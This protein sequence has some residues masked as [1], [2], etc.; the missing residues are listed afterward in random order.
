MRPGAFPAV[1]ALTCAVAATAAA[2][3]ELLPA[4]TGLGWEN[5]WVREWRRDIPGLE[6]RDRVA[7]TPGFVKVVRRWTWNGGKPLRDVVLSL[8]Y[9]MNGDPAA[10]KPFIPGTL[11]FGNPSNKGR[12]DGRVPVYSGEE[13][14]FAIFEEHRLP[15]PFAMLENAKTGDFAALHPVPSPIPVSMGA[16]CEDQWWSIGVAARKD[17]ADIVVLSGPIGYNRR[18][19][20]V[21]S[22][23]YDWGDPWEDVCITLAPGQSVEKTVLVQTGKASP[24]AAGFERCVDASLSLYRPEQFLERH[25]KVDEIL[26]VKRDYIMSRWIDE[27]GMRGFNEWDP[28]FGGTK[29]LKTIHLGWTGCTAAPAYA[30]AVLNLGEGDRDKAQKTLD[31]IADRFGPTIAPG[32]GTFKTMLDVRTG[33]LSGGDPV[34]CGQALYSVLKAV[35]FAERNPSSG[36]DPAKWKEFSRKASREIAVGLLA[37]NWHAPKS[38]GAAFLIAPLV[39]A[40][41][42][43]SMPECFAAA[44][45]LADF[46]A[47]NYS[48][49]DKTYWGGSLDATC[50]DKEGAMAAF[51][52][53]VA[54]LRHAIA[55]GDAAEEKRFA[56]L[57]RHAMHMALSWTVVWNITMPRGRTL[58]KARFR[59]AGWTVV[60]VQ[61]QCLDVFAL[62]TVPELVWM[63][64]Y[65]GDRRLEDLAMLMF[66]SCFQLTA[67]DG[68]TGEQILHTN[69]RHMWDDFRLIGK[70][71]DPRTF[72]GGFDPWNP[73]WL[74]GH[75]LC[76]AA[77]LESLPPLPGGRA[78]LAEP[79]AHRA[80]QP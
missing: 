2:R 22:R 9:R 24:D 72:R 53:Y 52:G 54:M 65:L 37:E 19:S 61:N 75:F 56:R 67:A 1:C 46:Y 68:N 5:G 36:L 18:R 58:S 64:G 32:N 41:E 77:D 20:I 43:Y 69:Y 63:G 30:L 21:K 57:A 73:I 60:S 71:G 15:M 55:A 38:S 25:A 70:R 51:Q 79:H 76:A 11:I 50:E 28:G 47:K 80:D 42:M 13:G 78:G 10:L 49:F 59:S 35:R 44:R 40:S 45:K 29:G 33:R 34:S 6:V 48:G 7:Q 74:W 39:L 66:R 23:P 14:E 31:F 17:G 26:R 62:L 12:G 27:K 4:E 8:R 16:A 3:A